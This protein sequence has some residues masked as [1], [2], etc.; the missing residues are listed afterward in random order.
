M[1]LCWLAT[2]ALLIILSFLAE[3]TPNIEFGISMEDSSTIRLPTTMLLLAL[4]GLPTEIT[5]LLDHSRCSDSATNLDGPT[6][7]ISLRLD[8]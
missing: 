1:V 3:R 5:S 7:S 8:P 2:G 4:S 6:L